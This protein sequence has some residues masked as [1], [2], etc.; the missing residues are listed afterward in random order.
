MRLPP[1]TDIGANLLHRQ[2]DPDREA[3]IDRAHAA[4][5]TRMLVTCTDLDESARGIEFCR[6]RADGLWC[7]AGVHPHDAKHTEPGWLT[8]LADLA[9]N[10]QVRAV[11]ETGLDFNRNF[12]PPERQIEVFEAQLELAVRIGKPVFV[13]DRDSQGK[14]HELLSRH[15]REL[16]GVVVHCF[17]GASEDLVHYLDAGFFVGITGWVCDE[18]RGQ[19]LQDLVPDIP[20]DQLLVETDAPFLF[21]RNAP[22][23][24]VKSPNKNRNEPALLRYVIE[25]VAQL[26]GCDPSAIAH[27]THRNASVLFGLAEG[28]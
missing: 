25:K 20:L 7:T 27:A 19:Q 12:S 8:R 14:V 24:A 21:P 11:G 4:G 16:C 15:A 26:R 2:F 10:A 28:E 5:V 13:H 9:G 17:T 6:G 3:V 18:R 23:Q 22:A 1:C